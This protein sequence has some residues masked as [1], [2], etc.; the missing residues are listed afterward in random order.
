LARLR[1]LAAAY[2]EVYLC[3]YLMGGTLCIMHAE[4]TRAAARPGDI[5]RLTG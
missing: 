4:I 5:G 3:D 1:I 2:R